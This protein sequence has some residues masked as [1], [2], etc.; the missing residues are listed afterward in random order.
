MANDS[1]LEKM[2]NKE[3]FTSM[4]ELKKHIKALLEQIH[5]SGQYGYALYSNEIVDLLYK[6]IKDP[7]RKYYKR[8][9]EGLVEFVTHLP[10]HGVPLKDRNHIVEKVL[11]RYTD[12]LRTI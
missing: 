8:P 9:V 1:L 10:L 2:F 12:S 7:E 5:A 4:E 3:N 6:P 11:Q